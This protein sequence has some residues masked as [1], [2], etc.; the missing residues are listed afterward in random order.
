MLFFESL[1]SPFPPTLRQLP[2]LVRR[3]TGDLDGASMGAV[4]YIL[5]PLSAL[6]G[7]PKLAPELFRPIEKAAPKELLRRGRYFFLCCL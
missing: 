3:Q 5:L 2:Q 6:S 4:T 1:I 7:V